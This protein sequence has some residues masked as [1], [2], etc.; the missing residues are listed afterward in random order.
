[1]ERNTLIRN[2]TLL[3]TTLVSLAILGSLLTGTVNADEALDQVN[4]EVEQTAAQIN[5][6]HGILLTSAEREN[7]KLSIIVKKVTTTDEDVQLSVVET[8]NQAIETY[9][10][11]DPTNQRKLLIE[12][13]TNGFGGA[14]KVPPM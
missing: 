3:K 4:A 9:E 8:T 2:N 7:L 6:D 10:I 12:I 14:G 11:T 1:M 13:E 5:A